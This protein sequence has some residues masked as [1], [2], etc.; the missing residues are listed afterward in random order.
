MRLQLPRSQGATKEELPATD[1]VAILACFA[2]SDLLRILYYALWRI[3][4]DC[5]HQWELLPNWELF[6]PVVAQ[7]IQQ[8]KLNLNS[9]L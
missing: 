7:Q 3:H 6:P 2:V 5:L 9:S 1:T 4:H 8:G